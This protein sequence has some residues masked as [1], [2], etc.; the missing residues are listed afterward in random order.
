MNDLDLITAFPTTPSN[1]DNKS[2]TGKDIT[3]SE[4]NDLYMRAVSLYQHKHYDEC[5]RITKSVL[6]IAPDHPQATQ[7]CKHLVTKQYAFD[8]MDTNTS[9]KSKNIR[10]RF[11]TIGATRSRNKSDTSSRKKMGFSL[12]GKKNDKGKE[13]KNEDTE[14]KEDDA[15]RATRLTL[16]ETMETEEI[17]DDVVKEEKKQDLKEEEE[18]I[19][20]CQL[21]VELYTN[22]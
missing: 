9:S 11:K 6:R 1:D 19:H 17:D 21:E 13:T 8:D 14:N 15:Q 18:E 12:F 5:E 20:P 2:P 4:I 16:L 22:M 10:Q 3:D 7:L